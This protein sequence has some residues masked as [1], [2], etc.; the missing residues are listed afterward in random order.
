M[1]RTRLAAAAGVAALTLGATVAAAEPVEDDDSQTVTIT[2][3]ASSRDINVGPAGG[4]SVEAGGV[5][6]ATSTSTLD[7]TSGAS[8]AKIT[9]D[10]DNVT[11]IEGV[12]SL[13][14]S[15]EASG[16]SEA[17]GTAAT[18][19][20]FALDLSG[21]RV[22]DLVTGIASGETVPEKTVTYTL[23]GTAPSEETSIDV[24]LI[25]TITDD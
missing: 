12:G 16:M 25:F 19:P 13:T 21:A 14:L 17:A 18:G 1:S 5:A 24:D 3:T 4:L 6:T 8:D 22:G 20:T 11:T 9:V 2:V 15:V 7:Y 10:L 23:G